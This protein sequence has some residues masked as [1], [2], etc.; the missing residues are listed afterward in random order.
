LPAIENIIPI[1]TNMTLGSFIVAPPVTF[2]LKLLARIRPL[3]ARRGNYSF[4]D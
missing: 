3:P 1:K 2:K 4:S